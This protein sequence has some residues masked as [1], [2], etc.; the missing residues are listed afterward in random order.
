MDSFYNFTAENA[1]GQVIKMSD[2]RGKVVLVVNTASK[3]GFTKQYAGLEKLY[4]DYKNKDFV[5]LAFPC[6]QFAG[7]E[8]GSEA[9]IVSFCQLNYGISFPIFKKVKVNGQETHPLFVY[10]KKELPEILGGRIKWNFTKFLID[11]AGS[12]LKRFSPATTPEEIEKYLLANK[13]LQ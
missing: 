8:P 1:N 5:I 11:S 4:Q 7:Q 6:N 10:L 13:I 2:Y 9:E 12:P 3:C